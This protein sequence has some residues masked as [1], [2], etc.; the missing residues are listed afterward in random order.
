MSRVILQYLPAFWVV[1]LITAGMNA[2]ITMGLYF[3]NSAGALSA[4]HATIAG[5]GAYLGAVLTT[6]FGS[7]VIPGIHNSM[8]SGQI[9][10]ARISPAGFF[11]TNA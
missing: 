1:T 2:I 9:R 8:I 7:L 5:M 6:N 4:A 10:N 11:E 3:S